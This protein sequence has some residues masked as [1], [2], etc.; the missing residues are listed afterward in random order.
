MKPRQRSKKSITAYWYGYPNGK[1]KQYTKAGFKTEKDARRYAR[2]QEHA[3]QVGDYVEPSRQT[4][5]DFIENEW[6]E[7]KRPSIRDTSFEDYQE[8]IKYYILPQIGGI[9]LQK[10]RGIHRSRFYTYL[11]QQGRKNGSGI[12]TST[13]KRIHGILGA[14][15]AYGKTVGVVPPNAAVDAPIPKLQVPETN[16]WTSDQLRS[17]LGGV[18]DQRLGPAFYVAAMTGL[19]HEEILGLRWKDVD[20][21][22]HLI[23]IH[24][25]VVRVGGET[26]ISKPKTPSS[27]RPVPI[28]A[29]TAAVLLVQKDR[30]DHEKKLVDSGYL[31]FDLVF[32]RVDGRPLHPDYMSTAFVRA[33]RRSGLPRIRL[34]DLRHTHATIG[35]EAHVD[36]K[37]MSKR[38]GHSNVNFTMNRYM[39]STEPLQREAAADIARFVFGVPGTKDP[40]FDDPPMTE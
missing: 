19:R 40:G 28:V 1:R 30:Q 10:F 34:H 4:L 3:I 31:D 33:V 35:L 20:F 7:M 14:A 22:S 21:A 6:L 15:L 26:K 17:F 11:L 24:Q 9:E 8:T 18:M 23:H 29:E 13:L 12:S 32:A 2:A 16:V 5:G 25:T 27:Q 37:T 38:L 36:P 39:R